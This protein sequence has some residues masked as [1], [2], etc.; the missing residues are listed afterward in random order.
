MFICLVATLEPSLKL[1]LIRPVDI[2]SSNQKFVNIDGQ[3]LDVNEH[4][5]H[6]F[7]KSF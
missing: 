7:V 5:C 1:L 4:E 2:D 6:K 3:T